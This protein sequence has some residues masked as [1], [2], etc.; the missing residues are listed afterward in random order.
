[1]TIF[2]LG[3]KEKQLEELLY[4]NGGEYTPEIADALADNE[5]ALRA[6]ADG[7]CLII[8]DLTYQAKACREEAQLFSEK[9]RKAEAAVKRL[10]THILGSMNRFGWGSLQGKDVE[11]KPRETHSVDVC[12]ERLFESL[13]L[14]DSIKSL[15]LPEYITLKPVINKNTLKAIDKA[16][17]ELPEGCRIASDYAL[18]MR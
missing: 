8:K 3:E 16:G 7:Y 14:A 4:E 9:A 18:I 10:K 17:E 2:D 13:N 11:F 15:N 1:M 6:K 12:E 5:E